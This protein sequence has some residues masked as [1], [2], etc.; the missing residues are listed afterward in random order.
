MHTSQTRGDREC[1]PESEN[2]K[3]TGGQRKAKK[4]LGEG[5]RNPQSKNIKTKEKFTRKQG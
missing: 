5:V 4:V 1:P 3:T 2:F